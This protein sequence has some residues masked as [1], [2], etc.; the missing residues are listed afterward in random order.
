MK[1]GLCLLSAIILLLTLCGCKKTNA[2][3]EAEKAITAIGQVTIES[4]EAICYAE[5]LYSILS[6]REKESISNRLDLANAREEY[7][8]L[9]RESSAIEDIS[10]IEDS[11][12]HTHNFSEWKY[13]ANEAFGNTSYMRDCS[14]CGETQYTQ[15]IDMS[16]ISLSVPAITANTNEITLLSLYN[17]T[18]SND[19]TVSAN[20]ITWHSDDL[21]II[22]NVVFPMAAGVYRLEAT[23]STYSKT[24]YL[25][26]K[27]PQD[28][29]YVLYSDD[30]DKDTLNNYRVVE[31]QDGSEYSISDGKL[32][33]DAFNDKDAY[34]RILLPEW[35]G[36]FADYEIATTFTITRALD[37]TKWFA[38]MARVQEE[39]YPYWHAAVRQNAKLYNGVEITSRTKASGANSGWKVPYKT[40][41]KEPIDPGTFYT[42]IFRLTGNYA[43]HSINGI[44]LL[45][46]NSMTLSC[47]DVGFQVRGATAAIDRVRII[48]PATH[49]KYAANDFTVTSDPLCNTEGIQSNIRAIAHRGYSEMAPE[50]TLVAYR[51]AKENGFDFV[52]CDVSFTSDGIAVLLHDNTINRTSN[53]TGSVSKMTYEELLQFDFGSW[54]SDD[55]T[56]TK[57]PTFEEFI[58]LCKE[59]ELH[60]YIELKRSNNFSVEY[61]HN[62]V[63]IVSRYELT[64]KVTWISAELNY[65][66]YIRDIIPSARLG[67]VS[68]SDA[69]QTLIDKAKNLQ[70]G[71]NQVFLDLD[72]AKVSKSGI[73]RAF[74]NGLAL[75]V[76]TVNSESSMLSLPYYVSGITSNFLLAPNVIQNSRT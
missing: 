24:I 40:S 64:N 14:E 8:R 61:A 38:T 35:I 71:T 29:E 48:I 76:Y 41:F 30:F 62:L 20:D 44:T 33:L 53:G 60:P 66:T 7:D 56:G 46:S 34:L 31:I 9:L 57:I 16:T 18:F 22:N 50:N 3:I 70:N 73:E 11:K 32:I 12:P 26:V 47:G 36:D 10:A 51:L 45:E 15:T 68:S 5:K 21:E 13:T 27:E 6:D 42:Q 75:E 17:I 65:L 54:K 67:V 28:T 23:Y 39:D 59:L 1:R 37:N 2:E 19:L 43:S 74:T 63:D 52:E 49:T 58:R 69:T 55:Y 72:Y 25:L 4:E